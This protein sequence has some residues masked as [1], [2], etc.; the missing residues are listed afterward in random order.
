MG[1]SN[2]VVGKSNEVVG[3]SN[4][5]VG[6]SSESY[7]DTLSGP[8]DIDG[9]THARKEL[10]LVVERLEDLHKKQMDQLLL[11]LAES[12]TSDMQNK[13]QSLEVV[14]NHLNQ[15][16]GQSASPEL[17]A[18]YD[19][20][21]RERD[22]KIADIEERL[23]S[24]RKHQTPTMQHYTMLESKTQELELRIAKRDIDLARATQQSQDLVSYP[25]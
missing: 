17:I 3:K 25:R 20:R 2:E 1:K 5:L 9:H 19:Q 6:K 22:K 14:I 11:R 24:A 16:L 23:R 18:N 4:E 12:P 7:G 21:L 15:K 10:A 8:S 13:I